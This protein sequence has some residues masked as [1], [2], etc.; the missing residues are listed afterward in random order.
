M[1]SCSVHAAVAHVG[2]PMSIMGVQVPIGQNLLEAAHEHDVD[3]EGAPSVTHRC[4]PPGLSRVYTP[5]LHAEPRRAVGEDCCS[6]QCSS[7][8][9]GCATLPL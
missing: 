8:Q 9:A 2:L 5:S 4:P 7:M 1:C 3:L 6:S